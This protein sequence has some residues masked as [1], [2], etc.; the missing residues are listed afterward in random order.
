MKHTLSNP[1]RLHYNLMDGQYFS[2]VYPNRNRGTK[3]HEFVS[4]EVAEELLNILKIA[5]GE[6]Q[7]QRML[8][9]SINKSFGNPEPLVSMWV[10]LA[11]AAIERLS[12]NDLKKAS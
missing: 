12:P 7:S 4:K 5:V 1:L 9:V 3:I 10:S 8:M 11:K 2:N 6:E